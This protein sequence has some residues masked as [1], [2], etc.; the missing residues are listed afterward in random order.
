MQ[1]AAPTARATT[2]GDNLNERQK[3]KLD[4]VI[5]FGGGENVGMEFWLPF[6]WLCSTR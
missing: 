5:G 4:N 1:R 3:A 6:L 2:L